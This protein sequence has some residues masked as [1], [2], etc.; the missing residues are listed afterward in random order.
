MG[1]LSDI[2]RDSRRQDAERA[3]AAS[4]LADY[5]PQPEMLADLIQDA[6][7]G[8]FGVLFPKLAGNPVAAL[9]L[10]IGTVKKPLDAEKND[11]DKETLA[12]RQAN[13][14]MA[15][16][17]LG[18][19]DPVWPLLRH[20]PDPR[21]RSY[22]IHRLSPLLAD[23]KP[24]VD[25][26]DVEK[27]VSI[28]RALLLGLGEFRPEQLSPADDW[29][30]LILKVLQVYREDPDAGMHAAADWF[31][32]QWGRADDLKKIDRAW[33]ED[34]R[35]REEKLEQI[36]KGLAEEGRGDGYWYVNG[37]GPTMVVVPR[38]REPFLMG[39]PPTE[40][41]RQG[42]PEGEEERQVRKRI[43]RSFAIAA[44]EVTVEQFKRCPRF[45]N[46]DYNKQYS[47]TPDC[48]V[49]KVTWFE[50]AEYC[51]WLT[52]MELP[53]EEWKD[54]WCYL[55]NADGKYAEGMKLAPDFLARTGYR[56]PTE[57]EWEYACRAGA[58]TSRYYGETDE[59]LT[60]YAWYAKNCAR[61]GDVARTT[62]SAGRKPEAERPGTFR[63]A[64]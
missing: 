21:A 34:R 50:A 6:N 5:V 19:A 31:L 49:N 43:G 64:G 48:P 10:L 45:E 52:E 1:P 17:R 51:N 63:H 41:G 57:A 59:L 38:P 4:I 15:L 13:A 58:V 20:S 18:Q 46:Y 25:R 29:G 42:G 16:L 14:A 33:A 62:R 60:K 32:R 61:P 55:P 30:S 23:P 47:P 24:L 36:R 37:Q 40:A 2:F 28:R 56:L 3:L 12:K 39:S 22:L 8:Q 9:A 11:A 26:L 35:R 44:R 27:E 7:E 53:K 54:Q